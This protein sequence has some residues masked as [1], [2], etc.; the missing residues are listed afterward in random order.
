MAAAT[1]PPRRVPI[2]LLYWGGADAY[3]TD[4]PVVADAGIAT[5]ASDFPDGF[6]NPPGGLPRGVAADVTFLRAWHLSPTVY[7]GGCEH[8]LLPFTCEAA[9]PHRSLPTAGQVAADLH[10]PDFVAG[11]PGVRLDTAHPPWVP[12]SWE[13]VGVD[14][15]HTVAD[16]NFLFCHDAD[17][18]EEAE[19]AHAE[20]AA[21]TRAGMVR[22][23]RSLAAL[24]AY[25]LH[26]HVYFVVV[27]TAKTATEAGA[28]TGKPHT[29]LLWAVGVSPSSGNLVGAW[30][31]QVCSGLCD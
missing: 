5:F 15:L 30:G 20:A 24:R 22:S 23:N 2:E 13:A 31:T 28:A 21:E 6:D 17:L 4:Q 9:V 19:P 27:H 10:K 8:P 1:S 18:D 3:P 16:E 14:Q 29:V 11:A 26:G 7:Y 25:V 12:E